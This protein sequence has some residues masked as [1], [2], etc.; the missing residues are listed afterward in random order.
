MVISPD[1]PML[2]SVA[3]ATVPAHVLAVPPLLMRAPFDEIPVPFKVNASVAEEVNE[4]PFKS[5]TAPEVTETPPAFDPKGPDEPKVDETP[6]F[7]VPAVI[8][9]APVYVFAPESV[10]VPDPDFVKAPVVLLPELPDIV[11][12]VPAVDISIV[13][14]VAAVKE[15]ALLVD[16]DEPVYCRVPPPRTMF[17]TTFVA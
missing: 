7:N 4:K 12:L 14:A 2:A 17:P 11:K 9:V 16:A 1:P 6:N 3:K 10:S 5:N 15:N 8:E 13:L